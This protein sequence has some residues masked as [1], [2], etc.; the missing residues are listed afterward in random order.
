MRAQLYA[1]LRGFRFMNTEVHLNK[2]MRYIAIGVLNTA[3][4]FTIGLLGLYSL[5]NLLPTPVIGTLTSGLC[6]VLNFIMY[7]KVVFASTASIFSEFIKFA[8]VYLGSSLLGISVLTLCI[9]Y[10]NTSLFLGQLS[11]AI[12]SIAVA[13]AGNFLYAFRAK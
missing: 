10:L 5:H 7:R 11:A 9:D 2:G 8:Q 13:M 3:M 6:I 4:G 12:S 1:N